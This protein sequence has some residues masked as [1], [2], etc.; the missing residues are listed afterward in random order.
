MHTESG[1]EILENEKTFTESEIVSDIQNGGVDFTCCTEIVPGPVHWTL[2]G[3]EVFEPEID[4][5]PITVQ[6]TV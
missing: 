1:P 6:N 3:F 5:L 2:T 4:P